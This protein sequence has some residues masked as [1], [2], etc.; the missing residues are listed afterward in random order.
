MVYFV[1]YNNL[2]DCLLYKPFIIIH[3]GGM[4]YIVTIKTIIQTIKFRSKISTFLITEYLNYTKSN[5]LCTLCWG[6]YKWTNKFWLHYNNINS[7]LS[8]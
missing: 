7:E 2:K 1:C 5:F 8:L 4:S 6:N 3:I